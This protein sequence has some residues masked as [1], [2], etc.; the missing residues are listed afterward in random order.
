MIKWRNLT[1]AELKSNYRNH[2]FSTHKEILKKKLVFKH[3]HL[4]NYELMSD[5]EHTY[6]LP[7]FIRPGRTHLFIRDAYDLNYNTDIFNRRR[8]DSGGLISKQDS[9]G[10]VKNRGYR[11]YYSRHI[12]PVREEPIPKISKQMKRTFKQNK[13]VKEYSVFRD[14]KEDT[15]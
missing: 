1:K 10:D 6:V 4:I 5:P 11:F 8:G 7:I 14:W 9:T 3:P 15:K 2:L 12:V 13:F